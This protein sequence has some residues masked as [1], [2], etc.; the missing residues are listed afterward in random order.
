MHVIK[1]SPFYSFIQLLSSLIS[2]WYAFFLIQKFR[3]YRVI[4]TKW[5]WRFRSRI[6]VQRELASHIKTS[7][8]VLWDLYVVV[9]LKGRIL[10]LHNEYF[11]WNLI[12]ISIAE[13]HHFGAL[14]WICI[15]HLRFT[16]F[17]LEPSSIL[18]KINCL[19][20]KSLPCFLGKSWHFLGINVYL[21][22]F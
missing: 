14:I 16:D 7:I 17:S 15:V 18:L 6:L 20:K 21:C 1:S 10:W 9:T 22:I 11:A 4:F 8:S 12:F 13:V 2:W 19:I 3:V 5:S